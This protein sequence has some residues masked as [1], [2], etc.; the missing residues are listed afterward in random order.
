MSVP[1]NELRYRQLQFIGGRILEA[2]ELNWIQEITEGVEVTDNE[3]P[4]DGELQSQFRQGAIYNTTI[5]I[6]GLIVTLS[7]TD[8]TKPMMIFVRDRW[9]IYP[10]LNDD[11]TDYTGTHSANHTIALNDV[12]TTIYL[13]W[14]YK[15]RTSSDDPTL[16]DPVTSEPVANAAELILHISY[17]DTSGTALSGSQLAKNTSAIP[18]LTFTNSGTLLTLVP[19]DNVLTPALASSITSGFVSTKK[20]PNCCI[21]R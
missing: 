21:N 17:Q 14:E 16:V 9:E 10:G 18:L 1:Y 20:Y 6:S 7:A 19:T 13:N 12:E 5:G 2:R 11:V 3:T 8:P 4:V 15:I